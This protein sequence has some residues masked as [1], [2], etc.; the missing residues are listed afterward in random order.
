VAGGR[1][2]RAGRKPQ[3]GKLGCENPKGEEEPKEAERDNWRGV[4]KQAKRRQRAHFPTPQR[5]KCNKKTKG[6]K[7][8]YEGF[9]EGEVMRMKWGLGGRE[10]ARRLGAEIATRHQFLKQN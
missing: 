10:V 1:V 6:N 7:N 9:K 4:S 8:T 2:A 5:K 3:E